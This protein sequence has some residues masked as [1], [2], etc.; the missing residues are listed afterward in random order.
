MAGLDADCITVSLVGAPA[1]FIFRD[2]LKDFA[3][4]A[5]DVVTAGFGSVGVSQIFKIIPVCLGTGARIANIMAG[6]GCGS[7]PFAPWAVIIAD[8]Q[9]LF[10]NVHDSFLQ[11]KKAPG[12]PQGQL[13]RCN[14]FCW[15][16]FS[17]PVDHSRTRIIYI[18]Q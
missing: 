10:L 6:Y 18:V 1:D 12:Y 3:V 14:L 2:Q 8:C 16:Q 9:V 11:L 7:G 13:H 17:I 15:Y 4:Q 5:D